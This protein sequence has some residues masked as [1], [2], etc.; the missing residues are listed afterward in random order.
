MPKYTV[1][2]IPFLLKP[3]L[4]LFGWIG[5]I[6][7]YLVYFTFRRLCRIEY[8]GSEHVNNARNFIFCLW[9]E[10]TPLYFTAHPRFK[11]KHIWLTL[12]LWYMKPVHVI[13][14]IIGIKVLAYGASGVDGKKALNQVLEKLA[15]GW[16]TFI[17]PDGP[18]GPVK[19]L[20]NGVLLMSL[21][22]GTPIIPVSFQVARN[23]RSN[24]W[25]KKRFPPFFSTFKVIYGKPVIITKENFDIVKIQIAE[26]MNEKT[27][28]LK[29]TTTLP[30]V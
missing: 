16:S 21:K 6:Y 1:Q 2:N 15:I 14:K 29:G 10:N 19:E 26:A 12:P 9:H 25:D 3:F 27:T 13:K 7:L 18:K 30:Y 23:W 22:T 28:S 11:R 8:I 24:S 5:G 20:K 17:N 4:L